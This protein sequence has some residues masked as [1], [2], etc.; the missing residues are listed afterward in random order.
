MKK[1]LGI[2]QPFINTYTSYGAA[3]SILPDSA[4]PWVLNNFIQ[5]NFVFDWNMAA[6]DSH[7]MLMNNCSTIDYYE[8]PKDILFYK[9]DSNLQDI[10][11]EG[12]NRGDYLFFYADWYYL[13]VSETHGKQHLPHEIFVY[14]Y[15]LDNDTVYVA[16][17]FNHGKFIFTQCSFQELT[18]AYMNIDS[19]YSYMG[20]IRYLRVHENTGY[21]LNVNQIVCGLDAYINSK[22]LYNINR[23]YEMLHGISIINYFLER[24]I[25]VRGDALDIRFFHLSY[26]QKKL[27]E[28]RV[29]YLMEQGII[30]KDVA[31]FDEFVALKK[32]ALILRN[33]VMKYE[34]SRDDTLFLK[35]YKELECVKEHDIKLFGKLSRLLKK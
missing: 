22:E 11:I 13:S 31:F 34:I 4:L 35:I 7:W 33:M 19:E 8:I 12:I 2:R 16:D 32:K 26:E 25:S 9:K 20:T 15:D 28:L 10:I 30:K 3:F 6:F 27:M 23:N 5:L 29:R 18:E 14:G 1:V 21:K 17:N 24:M